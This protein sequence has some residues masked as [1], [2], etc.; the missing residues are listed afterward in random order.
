MCI[1]EVLQRYFKKSNHFFCLGWKWPS[2]CYASFSS[3][4]VRVCV[5]KNHGTCTAVCSQ[6]VAK[7][8]SM[9]KISSLLPGGFQEPISFGILSL[10][11]EL[12]VQY[13]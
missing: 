9:Q 12:L 3:I 2:L 11:S 10:G 13:Y 8:F 7:H 5:R 4:A 1:G 6:A